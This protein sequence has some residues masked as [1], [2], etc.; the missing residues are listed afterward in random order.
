MR[1]HISRRAQRDLDEI[2]PYWAER[3]SVETA[4]RLLDTIEEH[5]ALLGEHPL[6]GQKCEEIAANVRV[7]PT[8]KYLM[9]YR[10][11]R[12]RVEILH[13]IH[14]ARDQARARRSE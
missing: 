5:V 13:V 7:F 11:A 8:G 10:K 9:Y 1:I 14:G 6:A 2:F 3:A 4:E 12:G